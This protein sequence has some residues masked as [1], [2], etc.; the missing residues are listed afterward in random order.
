LNPIGIM[1]GRLS[2][3]EGGRI[4]SFPVHTWRREFAL[5]REAGLDCIEW[6]YEVDTEVVNPLRTLAGVA[7]IA[8]LSRQSGVAVWSICAD[9]YMQE[10][11][12][13]KDGEPRG[14]AVDHL[15]SLIQRAAQLGVRYIVLPFVDASSLR[16]PGEMDG[17]LKVLAR[18]KTQAELSGIELHLE[19]DLHPAVLAELLKTVSHPLVRANY[20]IGNSASLRHNPAEE[21]GLIG[22]WLGS[23]H[24]K[25][26]LLGGGTVPLGTGAAD[27]DTSFRLIMQ[28]GFKGPFIL[29]AAR[30]EKVSDLQLAVRNR[31]FV[32]NQ[33]TAVIAKNEQ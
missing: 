7:E 4:Q 28:W 25:D 1:Q 15:L 24:V 2:P 19:T 9:F 18:V 14:A 33:I 32:K 11:L 29:Q 31:L 13:A 3:P 12:V 6:V 26:R 16:S 23:V 5:A 21:I 17:L 10:H 20:D 22:P 8:D 30:D 27:F